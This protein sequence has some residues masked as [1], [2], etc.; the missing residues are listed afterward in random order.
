MKKK[1][2]IT[3][4]VVIILVIL[5][6]G[7]YF[8][9]QNWMGKSR[10]YKVTSITDYSY[11][12]IKE[13][14]KYGVIDTKGNTIIP[15]NYDEV[16]IPNPTQAVFL[17]M[18]GE[19][20]SV[21]NEKA[22][23]ILTNYQNVNT[24]RLKNVSTDLI[25][26]KQVLTYEENGKLGLINLE[27]K[28]LTNAIYEEIDTLPYKEGELLVK[29]EG[30]YGVINQNGAIM[31]KPN[32]DQIKA[33]GY[34][35]EEKGYHEDGYLV[36][37]KTDQGYR[38]GYQ[39]FSG[40]E[41]LPTEF[42]EL[43]R[44]GDIGDNQ[45]VF[46]IAAKNGQYGLFQNKEA[47]LQNEYQSITYDTNTDMLIV[48]KGKKYGVYTPEGE[49]VISIEYPQID[50]NGDYFYVKQETGEIKVYD[51]QGKPTDI[52]PNLVILNTTAEEGKIKIHILT[53][54][55]TTKFNLYREEE[56]VTKQDY[57]YIEQLYGI[58][59][60]VANPSG[61]LGIIDAQGNA[62]TEMKYD[63]VQKIPE[64]NITQATISSTKQTDFYDQSGK[65]VGTLKEPSLKVEKAEQEYIIAQNQEQTLY[66]DL[67][68][69]AKTNTQIYPT[70]ALI[71]TQKAGKWGFSTPDGKQVIECQYD[72]VTELN[73][74][75]FAGIKQGDKW[76]VINEEGKIL[77]EP[78][79]S[80]PG[81]LNPQFV[82]KYYQVQYGYGQSYYTNS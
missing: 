70:H 43:E 25:Y 19:T 31:V 48:Q 52:D 24:L 78:T 75:G 39:T 71:A 45:N 82:G 54:N 68:G 5:G 11:F 47:K 62:K 26:E 72:Q 59:F 2:I 29:Q 60:V 38:Y 44:I 28:Q 21:L 9:W 13:N 50:S 56:K 74:Y 57:T 17:V 10:E 51:K 23:S 64:A 66:F 15:A 63:S 69:T 7:G 41:I 12:V 67:N 79:Y 35:D 49:K 30:K 40:E 1:V 80:L 8:I 81:Q 58:N 34:Y 16:Q 37:Q 32:Y 73:Q 77:L 65:L 53:E 3:L 76:G 46:L 61:K 33:D 18:Q 27:G 6:I 42:N 36:S 55:N 4:M 22:E 14:D 20:K